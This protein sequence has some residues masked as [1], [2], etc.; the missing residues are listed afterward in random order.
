VSRVS[1]FYPVTLGQRYILGSTTKPVMLCFLRVSKCDRRNYRRNY[2]P[3]MSLGHGNLVPQCYLCMS[4]SRIFPPGPWGFTK[5]GTVFGHVVMVTLFQQISLLSYTRKFISL[6]TDF[7][8]RFRVPV[9]ITNG[10]VCMCERVSWGRGGCGLGRDIS[11]VIRYTQT[12]G[13]RCERK[14]SLSVVINNNLV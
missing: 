1:P 3:H 4:R 11:T 9:V 2:N 12:G 10:P 5:S 14:K 6:T 8:Q 7:N 13:V